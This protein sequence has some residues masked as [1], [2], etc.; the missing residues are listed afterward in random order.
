MSADIPEGT[1]LLG[2]ELDDLQ[3]NVSV[4]NSG[5]GGTL[6]YVTGYTGFSGE[7]ELQSGN[8]LVL[9]CDTGAIS[10]STITC[11]L[12]GG[13][14]GPAT[15][16]PDGIIIFRVKN[17][18]QKVKVTASKDGYATVTRTYDLASLILQSE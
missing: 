14:Y 10:G 8:Y 15:L 18:Q 4:G 2:K 6:H 13:D 12:I 16:D 7:T 17:K 5:I 9:K 1:D 11:E 3:V